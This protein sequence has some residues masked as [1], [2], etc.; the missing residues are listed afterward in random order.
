MKPLTCAAARRRLQA[1]YD[2]QVPI[3]DQIAVSNHLE[4]CDACADSFAEL[5]WL[6][7]TLRSCANSRAAL[8]D[9]EAFRLEQSI[10]YRATAER[11][12]SFQARL[13]RRLEDVH[14]VYAGLGVAAGVIVCAIV[15]LGTMRLAFSGERPDSLA[16]VLRILASPGSNQ[17]P[18]A[19]RP[20]VRMPRP[21]DGDV[22]A[23]PTIEAGDA[24]FLLRGVVTQEGRIDYIELLN[25]GQAVPPGT[26]EATAVEN[27][28]GTVADAQFEPGSRAG[29]PVAVNMVWIVAHTTVRASKA[30]QVPTLRARQSPSRRG[31]VS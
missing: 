14:F 13:R 9:E 23:A 15:V 24:L 8:P 30:L 28:M 22:L 2:E 11:D 25:A 26:D 4:W 17:N 20:D 18:L 31:V 27:L 10:V 1:F 29:M 7:Q 3:A 6:G 12:T 19:L 21:L 5:R 16:A